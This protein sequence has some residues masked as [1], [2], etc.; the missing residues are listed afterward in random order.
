[1]HKRFFPLLV[2]FLGN[3][4]P[5]AAQTPAAQIVPKQDQIARIVT[6]VPTVA[7]AIARGTFPAARQSRKTRCPFQLPVRRSLRRS[8]EPG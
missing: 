3:L 4:V 1:M 2:L 6:V 8:S 5:A 7:G